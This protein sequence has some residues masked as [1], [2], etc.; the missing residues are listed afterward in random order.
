MPNVLDS[1]NS[2]PNEYDR[3]MSILKQNAGK[4]FVQRILYPDK[5]P[6]LDL[7][8]NTYGTHLMSWSDVDG[9]YVVFPTIQWNGKSLERLDP[10]LALYNALKN[11]EY[12]EF[13]DPQSADWFSK[14]YKSVWQPM[15]QPNAGFVR[16]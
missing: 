10:D 13:P 3:V 11:N 1:V 2:G 12:I 6:R 7:G 16:G 8:P 9:K 14:R 4:N 15:D 5:W